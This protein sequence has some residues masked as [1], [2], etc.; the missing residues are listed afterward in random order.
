MKGKE[1]DDILIRCDCG[2]F[3]FLEMGKWDEESIFYATITASPKT[4]SY[5]IKGILRL[6]SG[7]F[8]GITDEV[9][10]NKKEAKRLRDWLT[11]HV[12]K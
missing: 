9:L 8:Y 1:W 10:L 3:A 4:L 2:E 11:K 5:K 12:G 7:S 6:L